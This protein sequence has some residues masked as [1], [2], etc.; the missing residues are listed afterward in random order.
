MFVQAFDV[1][2]TAWFV[3]ISTL[4]TTWY[5]QFVY[6][7]DSTTLFVVTTMSGQEG[8]AGVSF[9]ARAAVQ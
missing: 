5:V 6:D 8:Y 7:S 2:R 4:P 3:A 1:L 9:V